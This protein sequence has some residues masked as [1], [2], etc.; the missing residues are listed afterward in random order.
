MKKILLVLVFVSLV[1]VATN[2]TT[3]VEQAQ[4]E[5]VTPFDWDMAA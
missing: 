4:G 3:N 5:V 2:T 1:A